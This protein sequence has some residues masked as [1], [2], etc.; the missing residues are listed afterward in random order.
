MI[1]IVGFVVSNANDRA[2]RKHASPWPPTGR[3]PAA[4]AAAI[5]LAT[6]SIIAFSTHRLV[7]FAIAQVFG[8]GLLGWTWSIGQTYVAELFPT[9]VRGTGFGL[10]VA[11]GRIPSIAGPVLTGT[12]IGSLGLATIAKWFAVLWLLYIVAFLVGPETRGRSLAE[13]DAVD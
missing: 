2:V 1:E 9:E 5:T 3:R 10:G 4:V 8:I 7:V 6:T 11:F 13:L 12:L